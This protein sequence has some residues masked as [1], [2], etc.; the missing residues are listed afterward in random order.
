M[1]SAANVEGIQARVRKRFEGAKGGSTSVDLPLSKTG[2]RVLEHAATEAAA[3]KQ[4]HIGTEHLL[5]GI[6]REASCVAAVILRDYGFD[7][8]RLRREAIRRAAAGVKAASAEARAAPSPFRDLVQEAESSESGLVGRQ[9]ELDCVIRILSRRTKNSAAL[10]GEAGVGKTAIV[11]GLAQRMAEGTVPSFLA[12][13]RLLA[14]D[15]SS[16]FIAEPRGESGGELEAALDN[17]IDPSNTILFIRGLFNLAVAGSAWK[18]VEAVRALDRLLAHDGMQCIATGS[19]QGLHAT[20]ERAATLARHFEV[21]AVNPANEED[22]IG[23][24]RSL[25][26]KFERFHEVTF[27]DGAIEAAVCA[28]RVFLPGRHLPD[29][30][31]DLMDEA[32]AAVKLRREAEPPEAAEVKKRIRQHVREMEKAIANHLFDEA[33]RHSDEERRQREILDQLAKEHNLDDA[34]RGMVTRSDIAAAIA[35]RTGVSVGAVERVLQTIAAG[36]FRGPAAELAAV[37]PGEDHSWLPFFAEYLGRCSR[38]EAD[39]LVRAITAVQE[40]KSSK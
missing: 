3:L 11:E 28:S 20:L 32:A 5:L 36:E 15:F 23:I 38:A 1:L 22:A 9:R 31:I 27:G 12:G 34:E 14:L 4:G 2:K 17:V 21:V 40:A 33:R 19:A 39:A 30:A 16:L 37:L 7:S 35:A 18:I 13:R 24:L 26:P 8:D 25:K 29:R 10:I 6:S